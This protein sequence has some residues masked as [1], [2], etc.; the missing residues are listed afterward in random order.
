M[1]GTVVQFTPPR[2]PTT[3]RASVACAHCAWGAVQTGDNAIEV[4]AFLRALLLRHVAERHLDVA[5]GDTLS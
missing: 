4:G 1:S 5:L 3:V 2:H